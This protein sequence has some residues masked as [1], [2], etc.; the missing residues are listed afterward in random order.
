MEYVLFFL[1]ICFTLVT[2]ALCIFFYFSV[3]RM[4]DE[5]KKKMH[6]LPSKIKFQE[7]K[8]P[9]LEGVSK[10][11]KTSSSPRF[12]D[13]VESAGGEVNTRIDKLTKAK[14]QCK[15]AIQHVES[16]N[17]EIPV[18]KPRTIFLDKIPLLHKLYL[19]SVNHFELLLEEF[20][21]S[22]NEKKAKVKQQYMEL[23]DEI[24]KQ[25]N[26]LKAISLEVQPLSK[27][28]PEDLVPMVFPDLGEYEISILK[29]YDFYAVSPKSKKFHDCIDI[30]TY[31]LKFKEAHYYFYRNVLVVDMPTG[32]CMIDYD[33]IKSGRGTTE[34]SRSGNGKYFSWSGAY[35][36]IQ[37]KLGGFK[38]KFACQNENVFTWLDTCFTLSS[39]H[40][41]YTNEDVRKEIIAEIER[42]K[43]EIEKERKRLE[44]EEADRRNRPDYYAALDWVEE[45]KETIIRAQDAMDSQTDKLKRLEAQTRLYDT[46]SKL[47]KASGKRQLKATGEAA[48]V[49]DNFYNNW[50]KSYI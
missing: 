21:S 18:R 6:A 25:L 24:D 19:L 22:I 38:V 33:D 23:I 34:I 47:I 36:E 28:F 37:S 15:D 8:I 3:F 49:Y 17:F 30:D 31:S 40:R 1:A 43:A 2:I 7:I 14:H 50:L 9:R 12:R 32:I 46:I 45:Q 5:E 16:Q 39:K 44:A 26:E 42:K 41:S 48:Q 27:S 11:N 4:S 29:G 13:Y 10:E 35:L 20:N